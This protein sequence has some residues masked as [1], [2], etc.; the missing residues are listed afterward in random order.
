MGNSFSFYAIVH[1]LIWWCFFLF[2][3]L[4]HN[5]KCWCD[6]DKVCFWCASLFLLFNANIDKIMDFLFIAG[7]LCK[8]LTGRLVA[9]VPTAFNWCWIWKTCKTLRPL[10]RENV[11][12]FLMTFW[13]VF[14]VSALRLWSF[15]SFFSWTKKSVYFV[16]INEVKQNFFFYL[17]Y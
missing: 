3:L 9:E 2:V 13:N 14:S 8:C 7:V 11:W 4:L 16:E 6:F 12:N 17:I 15:E 1:N 5:N 10:F